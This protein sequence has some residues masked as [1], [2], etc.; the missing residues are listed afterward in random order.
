MKKTIT[1]I[2]KNGFAGAVEVNLKKGDEIVEFNL[3]TTSDFVFFIEGEEEPRIVMVPSKSIIKSK[4]IMAK[5]V[6]GKV[7]MACQSKT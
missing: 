6:K 2:T 4:A 1:I 3:S 5:A 7:I